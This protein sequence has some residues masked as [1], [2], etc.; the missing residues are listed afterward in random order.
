MKFYKKVFSKTLTTA[1][2]CDIIYKVLTVFIICSSSG[3][4][5]RQI[6]E[7]LKAKPHNKNS[8]A[9]ISKRSQR[10]GLEK[11]LDSSLYSLKSLT[12]SRFFGYFFF[13][14]HTSSRM[15]LAFCSSIHKLIYGG[16]S[17]RSQRGGLENLQSRVSAKHQKAL[18]CL[19]FSPFRQSRK[20]FLL[21]LF[22]KNSQ[23]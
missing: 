7:S 22:L 21:K 4:Y 5:D 3:F 18:T 19:T 10:G 12:P 17:K 15:V 11:L 16:I 6:F 9:G 20:I 23:I 8:Y 1:S 2:K 13:L 14:Q